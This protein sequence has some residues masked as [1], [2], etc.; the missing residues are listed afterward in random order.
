MR[1]LF[2]RIDRATTDFA[3]ASGI[4]CAPGCGQCC[5]NPAVEAS[6]AELEPMAETLFA[7]GEAERVHALATAAHGRPCVL[8]A[9]DPADPRKGRCSRYGDRPTLC[10][11]FGFAAVRTRRPTPELAACRI[12]RQHDAA[13]VARGEALAERGEAPLM[14]DFGMELRALAG[15]GSQAELMPIN[16][17]IRL[18]I[19]RAFLRRMDAAPEAPR[20]SE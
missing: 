7:T 11:L 17:A 16:D 6:V 14:A 1:D 5:N 10:R 8:Y 2:A 9:A 13:A 19:E 4:T 12:H 3:A 15:A 20:L 18:A